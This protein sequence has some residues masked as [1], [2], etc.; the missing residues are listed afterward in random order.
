MTAIGKLLVR[1]LISVERVAVATVIAV[2][3]SSTD[4]PCSHAAAVLFG[5]AG[6]L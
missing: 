2:W 6:G 3:R 5:R 4:P 1:S